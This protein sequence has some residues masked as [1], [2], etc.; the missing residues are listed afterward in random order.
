MERVLDGKS[1]LAK[2][3]RTLSEPQQTSAPAEESR[4]I[5]E[6]SRPA[7]QTDEPTQIVAGKKNH[8]GSIELRMDTVVRATPASDGTRGAV[9]IRKSK[10]KAKDLINKGEGVRIPTTKEKKPRPTRE[11]RSERSAMQMLLL[12]GMGEHG[13]AIQNEPAVQVRPG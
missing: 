9:D 7:Y 2:E 5:S 12:S 1:T 13:N 10:A 11:E 6:T 3:F 4:S 8:D